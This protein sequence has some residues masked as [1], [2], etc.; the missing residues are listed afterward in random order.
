MKKIDCIL[1]VDDNPNENYFHT[2]IINEGNV[3]NHLKTVY[4][5]LEALEYLKESEIKGKENISPKPNLILLDINMPRMNGFDFLDEF[6]KLDVALT[7][8]III[9]MLSTS[10]N[11][12]DKI[13]A[14]K[15]L[16]VKEFITKPLDLEI[17]NKILDKY[18]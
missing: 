6:T 2:Y 12:Y 4:D 17:L 11:P 13:R 10:D 15:T 5:G 8:D 16:Q 9:A 18:F 7:S 3:C 14:M 1:L